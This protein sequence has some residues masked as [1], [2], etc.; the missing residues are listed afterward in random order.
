MATTFS[1]SKKHITSAAQGVVATPSAGTVQIITG[2][3][4]ANTYTGSIFVD[5]Y[6]VNS[7]QNYYLAKNAEIAV[8][9][10]MIVIGWDQKQILVNGDALYIKTV[11]S[12]QTADAVISLIGQPASIA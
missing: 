1:N 4:I 6:V 7:S 2:L 11:T 12:G 8:G 3:T 5:V 9:N 10:S